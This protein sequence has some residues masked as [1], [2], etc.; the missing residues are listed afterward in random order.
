MRRNDPTWNPWHG[1]R[2]YSEGCKNCF[3]FYL[4]EVRGQDGSNIS[5]NKTD[6]NLPLKRD[7][8]GNYKIKSG[9]F[10]RVCMSSDFFLEDADEWREEAWDIIRIRKD[11]TFSLLTKRANRIKECLPR[12]WGDGWDNVAFAVSCENQR[13][14]DE[15]IPYLLEI[16][17]KHKWISLKP[18][19]GEV[20][21]DKYLQSGQIETVLAGG[22]NYAGERPLHYEWVKKIY[23]QCMK[24][25]VEFIFGQTGNVFVKDGKEYHIKDYKTQ[26]DQALASGLQNRKEQN[27]FDEQIPFPETGLQF[28]Q[29]SLLEGDVEMTREGIIEFIKRQKTSIISSV[30]ED[31]Y[32]WTRALIQPRHVEGNDVYF[33]TYTSSNKVRHYCNNSKACIYFYEKGKDF[34]GV[35]IKGT[36]AVLTDQETK[37]KFWMPF[38][39]RFY[40]NGVTDPEYCILKFTCCEAQWFSNFKVQTVKMK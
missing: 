14:A 12:D 18:F 29:L 21:L 23:D 2:K 20:D 6:W 4:D 8:Q 16:P 37:D 17:A 10:V 13:R 39:K 15:R 1:C 32:P 9:E 3:M 5:R 38:Y 24:Y 25:D 40:K 26:I 35:M 22:E 31:G 36:M 28:E 7:R 34:Q 33:A 30:D 27:D 19:I 11:V